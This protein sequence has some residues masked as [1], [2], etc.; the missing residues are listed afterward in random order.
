MRSTHWSKLCARTA[1]CCWRR[2]GSARLIYSLF[3]YDSPDGPPLSFEGYRDVTSAD[4]QDFVVRLGRAKGHGRVL[5]YGGEPLGLLATGRFVLHIPP[6]NGGSLR[7]GA[8]V[9]PSVL[10]TGEGHE[11]WIRSRHPMRPRQWARSRWSSE[12]GPAAW[13]TA[14]AGNSLVGHGCPCVE[15]LQGQSLKL[16]PV[17]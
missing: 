6:L 8:L 5:L 9:L 2:C 14:P 13:P 12:T 10:K 1:A 11:F 16:H 4:V 7:G 17:P 15:N 3:V